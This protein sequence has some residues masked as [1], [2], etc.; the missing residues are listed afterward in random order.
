MTCKACN[1]STLLVYTIED[2]EGNVEARVR[3][4]VRCGYQ[5]ETRHGV[6]RNGTKQETKRQKAA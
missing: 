5:W 6:K 2:P 4:C 1:S 3:R